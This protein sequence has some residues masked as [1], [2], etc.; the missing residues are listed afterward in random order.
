MSERRP[1]RSQTLPSSEVALLRSLT[2]RQRNARSLA[3]FENGW[4]LQ[5]IGD[6][7]EPPI[8][9]STVKY[10]IQT[11][12]IEDNVDV[13]IPN[14][15]FKTP[16]GGYQRKKPP[17]PGISSSDEARLGQLAPL[18]RSYRAGMASTHPAALAN[19]EFNALVHELADQ[20][21]TP[22]E[23]ARAANVTFRAIARRLGR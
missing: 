16:K 11:A 6:A 8:R 7:F 21:V 10:W 15:K 2:K 9:R 5:S 14:P 22:A 19:Q 20:N 1:A 3:L 13:P 18:A 17:S 23:I 4:T 12:S